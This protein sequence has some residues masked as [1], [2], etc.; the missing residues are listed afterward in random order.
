MQFLFICNW[1]KR[2]FYMNIS[3][4]VQENIFRRRRTIL[5]NFSRWLQCS[6]FTIFFDDIFL[7]EPRFPSIFFIYISSSVY[8]CRCRNQLENWIC[9]Y[10]IQF[11]KSLKTEFTTTSRI[12]A[13]IYFRLMKIMFQI[14]WNEMYK[15][16][17]T[18]FLKLHLS[19][20]FR[21]YCPFRSKYIFFVSYSILTLF[22]KI[23]YDHSL[24][25]D[26]LWILW[27]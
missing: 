23:C 26:S 20:K 27:K 25:P 1:M 13:F 10:C 22:I 2:F 5:M 24:F 12:V 7:V 4:Y 8:F 16:P 6:K 15:L 17:A 19:A 9:T 11:E 3:D 21:K 14:K 18:D